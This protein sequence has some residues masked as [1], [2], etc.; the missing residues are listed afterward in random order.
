MENE[1]SSLLP[2]MILETNVGVLFVVCLFSCVSI[3]EGSKNPSE[4]LILFSVTSCP[5]WCSL[6]SETS[7]LRE[8]MIV[9]PTWEESTGLW[10]AADTS[11]METVLL[12]SLQELPN[13]QTNKEA[14][15]F[16]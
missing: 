1:S 11:E 5:F 9:L 7:L 13:N 10:R 14:K 4:L 3:L 16:R 6:R 8:E 2:P 15:G 12:S